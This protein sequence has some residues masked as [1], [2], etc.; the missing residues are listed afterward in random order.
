MTRR[1]FALPLLVA[2]IAAAVLRF[3]PARPAPPL[4]VAGSPSARVAD[5]LDHDF[6]AP[7][8]HS[9]VLLMT[10]LP[11]A[12]ASDSGRALVR[13]IVAPLSTIPGVQSVLSP[14][15][16]LD[17]LLLGDDGRSAIAIAG[18]APRVTAAELEEIRAGVASVGGAV[19]HWT[20]EPFLATD[21]AGITAHALRWAERV[22]VPIT[23]VA[24]MIAFGGAGTGL[25][26]V[27][28]AALSV[29]LALA[30]IRLLGTA[31]PLGALASPVATLI[32]MALALDYAIWRR[33]GGLGRRDVATA[34]LVAGCGFAALLLAPTAEIRGAAAAGLVAVASAAIV[35]RWHPPATSVARDRASRFATAVVTHRWT[36]LVVALVPLALLAAIALRAPLAADPLG[37]LPDSTPSLVAARDLRAVG[38]GTAAV[39]LLVLVDLA[40]DAPVFSA[41][42]WQRLRAV[43]S[44]IRAVPGVADTRGVTGIGTGE[45][46]VTGRVVPESVL[47]TFVSTRRD[48]ALIR[49]FAEPDTDLAAVRELAGRLVARFRDDRAV[50]IGGAA[51]MLG[52]FEAALEAALLPFVLLASLGS[53]LALAVIFRAPVVAAKA[54]VLNLLV[55]AAAVGV[56]TLSPAVAARGLPATVPLV[57]LGA[58]FA[59]S[60][61]YELL[62]L[63]QVRRAGAGD[64][65]AIALGATR[66]SGLFLRGGA[67]LVVVLAGF[68]A[69]AFAPLA[70]LGQVLIAAVALDVLLVRPVVAPALLAVLG[71][72]NW[73]PG[74]ID[75]RR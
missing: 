47:G 7:F 42:G 16:S 60:I 73:W 18:L 28:L 27:G 49:V 36:A 53:W 5:R 41:A 66:A 57:A 8:A 37:W 43:D 25:A 33:G 31:V 39:P 59:L 70:L 35:S 54:V 29:L 56:V 48:A 30:V 3:V 19:L 55:A 11:V 74:A 17:T 2:L 6:G 58:A 32:A 71:R 14:A 46:T 63:L 12:A 50:T 45:R 4:R 75:D 40:P 10:Q 20:G 15:T 51:V 65:A 38:R 72:W 9:V 26:A 34:A 68:A 69:S 44:T 1:A 24:A 22:A 64:H 23:V 21:V 62:L 61:D 52:D 67:L 13:A